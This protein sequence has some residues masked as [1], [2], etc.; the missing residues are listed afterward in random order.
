MGCAGSG[1]TSGVARPSPRDAVTVTQTL[2]GVSMR[3]EVA[4]ATLADD[5]AGLLCRCGYTEVCVEGRFV[6]IGRANP[7]LP[8]LE[9][10]RLAAFVDV[11][12]KRHAGASAVRRR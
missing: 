5:L 4:T 11:W 2:P 1:E 12:R 10:I 6:D 3:I 7:E 8:R 9:D